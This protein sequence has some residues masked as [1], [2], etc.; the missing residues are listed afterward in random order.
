MTRVRM[1]PHGRSRSIDADADADDSEGRRRR[2]RRRERER[3]R[4]RRCVGCQQAAQK[5]WLLEQYQYVQEEGEEDH[6]QTHAHAHGAKQ[7]DKVVGTGVKDAIGSNSNSN[8]ATGVQEVEFPPLPDQL[9]ATPTRPSSSVMSE[10]EPTTLL[11]PTP[12]PTTPTPTPTP[13]DLRLQELQNELLVCEA[14]VKDEASN[15][16]RS[17]YEIKELQKRTKHLRK[18]VQGMQQKVVKQRVQE[19]KDQRLARQ[20]E[21]VALASS[22]GGQATD[23]ATT[24]E[25][26]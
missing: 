1:V 18:Q 23:A 10:P 24:L 2:W 7:T 4:E 22:K 8:G 11:E 26:N 25:T 5:A 14:N 6:T 3:E 16:M 17:K 9:F 20:Q 19:E 12:T 21:E 13:E 15:Y